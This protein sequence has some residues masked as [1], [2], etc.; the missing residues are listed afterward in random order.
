MM[1]TLGGCWAFAACGYDPIATIMIKHI[2]LIT[3]V[4]DERHT[5]KKAESCLAMYFILRDE[6]DRLELISGKVHSW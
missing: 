5:L 3:R 2:L 4:L 1:T 6:Y